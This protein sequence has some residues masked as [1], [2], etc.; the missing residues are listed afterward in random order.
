MTKLLEDVFSE[1]S[2]L[3]E[4]EQNDFAQ[5]II[6]EL[7][8]DNSYSNSQEA[9]LSLAKEAETEYKTGKTKPFEEL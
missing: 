2:K 6:E 5:L 9:L 7:N 8:W 3:P 4:K 1:L